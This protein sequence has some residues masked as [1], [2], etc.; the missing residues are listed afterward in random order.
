MP[1]KQTDVVTLSLKT[2]KSVLLGGLARLHMREGL[3][4]SFTFYIANAVPIHPTTSDK[5]AATL[6]KH[7]GGLLAPP[8]SA[9]RL[10][11]LGAFVEQRFTVRGRG[12]DEVCGL[13]LGLGSGSGSGL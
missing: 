7:V 9:E 12:W 6:A 4:F 3:P 10:A 5:A 11:E 1:K 2:G 8:A 13:R